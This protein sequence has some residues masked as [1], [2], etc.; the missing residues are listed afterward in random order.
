MIR[1]SAVFVLLILSFFASGKELKTLIKEVKPSVVGVGVSTPM[2]SPSNSLQGTGFVIGN[3][4][5]IVTNYH[6]V[7]E[8]LDPEKVQHRVV[9]SGHGPNKIVHK[10]DMVGFD[11]VHDLAILKIKTNLTPMV[12]G[13]DYLV[14]EGE[15]IAFT[16]FP[17][18][19]VLGLYPATHTGI[20]AAI[21]PDVLPTRT[22]EH[23]TVNML[24]RLK[25]RFLIY[26][27]DATAYPG[28]SGSPLYKKDDGT[29]IGVINKVFVAEGKE[30]VLSKP[31]G[32]TYAIPIIHL[33]KLAAKH[34]VE[35]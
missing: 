27:L 29:V 4:Q 3:G 25:Q 6:V 8:P 22:T 30:S 34:N 15:S 2:E 28:N 1:K 10:A 35:I 17:I 5:Y 19:A 23:L 13:S 24:D 16:G 14:E 7:S 33:R 20:V 18:G 32:I 21:T 26:Q 12:L 9:F 11:P 31:S